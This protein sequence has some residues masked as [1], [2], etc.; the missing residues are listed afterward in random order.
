[1]NAN[2]IILLKNLFCSFELQKTP[3]PNHIEVNPW[4]CSLGTR[5]HTLT[6]DKWSADPG[7]KPVELPTEKKMVT[8]EPYATPNDV[9]YWDAQI[10]GS[11]EPGIYVLKEE[12]C[13]GDWEL[14]PN[15][16]SYRTW[17]FEVGR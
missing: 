5:I 9:E 7:L 13:N 11:L 1:M 10:L 8:A 2:D 4:D 16:W 6:L 14:N 17:I 12:K 15:I 3:V